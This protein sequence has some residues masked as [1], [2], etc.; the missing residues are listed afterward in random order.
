MK[1]IESS[2]LA[3]REDAFEVLVD[4]GSSQVA[5]MVLEPDQQSGEYGNDH[6]GSALWLYVIDGEGEALV[7]HEPIQLQKGDLLL[8]EPGEKHQII[9]KGVR[10]LRTINFYSPKA[11]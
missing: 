2:N 8:I 3:H 4:S 9:G 11:Y 7:N 10:A 5:S 1:L 6:P